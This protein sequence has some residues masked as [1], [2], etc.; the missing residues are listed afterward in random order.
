[1][2]LTIFDWWQPLIQSVNIG[3][4]QSKSVI[5][6]FNRKGTSLSAKWLYYFLLC[7]HIMGL[8]V[9]DSD[10][11]KW[12]KTKLPVL[13]TTLEI[14]LLPSGFQSQHG[15]IFSVKVSQ[16]C[17]AYNATGRHFSMLE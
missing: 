9:N 2:K 5:G 8:W 15:Q 12:K 7:I 14:I 1:M 6:M 17:F 4:L 11:V 10:Y 3:I 13:S 16:P